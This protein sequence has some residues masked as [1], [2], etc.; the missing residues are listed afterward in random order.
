MEL[1]RRGV[2]PRFRFPPLYFLRQGE[3]ERYFL[4]QHSFERD[5]VVLAVGRSQ[6]QC[7][8]LRGARDFSDTTITV[9]GA[10]GP[11]APPG[12]LSTAWLFY[13]DGRSPSP[14]TGVALGDRG[15]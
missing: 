2:Q 15:G 4:R 13:C 1:C 7:C 11:V 8:T 3:S 12:R 14:T 10:V 6:T 5:R 9:A